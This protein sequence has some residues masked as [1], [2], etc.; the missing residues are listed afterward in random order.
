MIR[1]LI[2]IREVQTQGIAM[3]YLGSIANVGAFLYHTMS[4]WCTQ[5]LNL[6]LPRLLLF[7]TS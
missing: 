7:D 6:L 3:L 5:L 2:K 1:A 4:G